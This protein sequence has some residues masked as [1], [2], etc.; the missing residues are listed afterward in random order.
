MMSIEIIHANDDCITLMTIIKK[1]YKKKN[2][3]K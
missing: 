1:C 3:T 2:R